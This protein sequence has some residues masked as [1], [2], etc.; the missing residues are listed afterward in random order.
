MDLDCGSTSDFGPGKRDIE[1]H[2]FTF[3]DRSGWVHAHSNLWNADHS[4]RL[5]AIDGHAV[6]IS[7]GGTTGAQAIHLEVGEQRGAPAESKSRRHGRVD[8]LFSVVE[9]DRVV[10]NI[11]TVVAGVAHLQ[12]MPGVDT[13]AVDVAGLGGLHPVIDG[14]LRRAGVFGVVPGTGIA[15]A[16]ESVDDGL[17]IG[18]DLVHIELEIGDASGRG[19]QVDPY[20]IEEVCGGGIGAEGNIVALAAGVGVGTVEFAGLSAYRRVGDEVH[21]PA[22]ASGGACIIGRLPVAERLDSADDGRIGGDGVGIGIGAGC[23]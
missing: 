13:P 18:H 20:I 11:A 9:P 8:G 6:E 22:G 1:L 19:G 3:P 12:V 16:L 15:V 5:P 17:P 23:S 2:V 7:T 21:V 4:R 14:R 10:S